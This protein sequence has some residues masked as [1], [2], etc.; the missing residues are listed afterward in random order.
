VADGRAREQA[1]VAIRP[2][3]A[4]DLELLRRLLGDAQMMRYL[5]G[6]ESPEAIGARHLRYLHAD[7]ET[8]GL[9]TVTL[10]PD[11]APAGWVGFWEAESSGETVW[12][13]GWHVLPEA[14]GRGVATRATALLVGEARRRRRHRW[15]HAYPGVDNAA[16]NALCRELGFT[17]LG[18]VEVEY[19]KGRQMRSYD[20]RLDLWPPHDPRMSAAGGEWSGEAREQALSRAPAF[21]RRFFAR[22]AE[23]LPPAAASAYFLRWS[24]QPADVY[25]VVDLPEGGF[26]VQVD[27]DLEYLVVWSAGERAEF[28]DWGGDQVEPALR[29][30][31]GLLSS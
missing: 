4:G 14:Q 18:E 28:G 30:V 7:P 13:C 6:P 2:Y 9:F 20:W 16:S 25:A 21:G 22:F 8:N 10:G 29:F 24:V 27:P 11:A 3:G 31:A 23:L 26:T 12:E 1:E 5:G 19:P 15:L 17:C